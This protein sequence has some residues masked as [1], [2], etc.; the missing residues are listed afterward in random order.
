MRV[1]AWFWVILVAASGCSRQQSDYHGDQKLTAAISDDVATLETAD[2]NDTI[3]TLVL[4]LLHDTLYQYSYLSK[5]F[6]VE[7]LI[8]ADMPRFSQD[9]LTVTIRI[10]K[11]ILFHDDPAF[12]SSQGK[13]RAVTADDFVYAFKRL[14]HPALQ[15][16]GWWILDG[17]IAGINA[18]HDKLAKAATKEE[19]IKILAEP[20]EGITAIDKYSLQF[21][22]VKPYPQLLYALTLSFTAPVANE[23]VTTYSDESGAVHG[24]AVGTGPFILREWTRHNRLVLDRNPQYHPQFYPSE[25]HDDFRKMGLLGLSSKP[26]PMLDRIELQVIKEDQPMW[27]KFMRGE[28]DISMIPKDNFELAMA[29]RE[30]LSESLRSKGIKLQTENGQIFY[31]LAFNMKD[32]LIGKNKI[33][34]QAISSAIDRSK[35]VALF[36]SGRGIPANSVLPPGLAGR[37]EDVVLKYGFNLNRAKKLLAQAGHPEGKGLPTLKFDMRSADSLSRQMGD[38]FI[39]QLGEIGVRLTI[40]YNSFPAFLD[41]AKHSNLQIFLGGWA[42]D[43]PDAENVY[44]LLYG[45]NAAPGPNDTNYN[46]AE[47]NTLFLKI[48]AMSPSAERTELLKQMEEIIQEEVPWA[49][50]F[51]TTSYFLSHPWV[52][53][54]RATNQIMNRLK[55]LRIDS[56]IK[57]RYLSSN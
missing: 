20:V 29:D 44:Q 45:P 34:R 46:N 35:W 13:G 51:Y 14:A 47:L 24:R 1:Q 5:P 6:K 49:L 57:A 39:Q 36:T 19:A 55:Y 52:E 21:K 38:F 37:S 18:F 43:Y 12:K 8:A 40:S 41:K 4:G 2:A 48:S 17:K 54:Y 7:P 42:L 50:G 32:P 33:L 16:Q 25:A 56:G 28:L 27:L 30:T 53:G 26:L 22:L 11:G 31:F 23:T 10:K 9:G 3:S 15:S